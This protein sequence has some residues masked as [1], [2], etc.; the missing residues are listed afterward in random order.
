MQV[1]KDSFCQ[2]R[3]GTFLVCIFHA[4]DETTPTL[5]CQEKSEERSA[6]ISGMKVAGGAGREATGENHRGIIEGKGPCRNRQGLNY[7]QA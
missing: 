2:L 3:W 1:V 6:G 4:Q 5:P 7:D